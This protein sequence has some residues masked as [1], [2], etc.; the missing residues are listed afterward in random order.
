MTVIIFSKS[1]CPFSQRAKGLLLEKYLI[2]PT[3][4]VVELDEHPL[5]PQL[6]ALLGEK[7]GR[8]T[9]PNIMINGISIGGS[10]DIAEL[11]TQKTLVGKVKE[12]GGK[13][14]EMKERFVEGKHPKA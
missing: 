6:Q 13:R 10:D 14:V 12:L 9:V 1:Y 2:E 8:R 4:H 3:P 11:E 5:G 7:T